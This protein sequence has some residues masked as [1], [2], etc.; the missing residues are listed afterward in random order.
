MM[1]AKELRAAERVAPG[2]RTAGAPVL[3]TYRPLRGRV[4]R[5]GEG[6]TDARGCA[7]KRGGRRDG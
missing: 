1:S 5:E 2:P 6:S 7:D 4:G 3:P